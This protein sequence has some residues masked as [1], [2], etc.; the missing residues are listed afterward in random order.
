MQQTQMKCIFF[1]SVSIRV[2]PWFKKSVNHGSGA[3][4]NS[5]GRPRQMKRTAR[6]CRA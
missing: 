3:Q 6:A 5:M 4:E 1:L 2:H